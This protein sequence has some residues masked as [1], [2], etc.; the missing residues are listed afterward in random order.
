MTVRP[1]LHGLLFGMVSRTAPLLSV[2][3][4]A[5]P[6][7]A[8]AIPIESASTDATLDS[9]F[10][11]CLSLQGEGE[12]S[13]SVYAHLS[14]LLVARRASHTAGCSTVISP[15]CAGSGIAA[16]IATTL[17]AVGLVRPHI[18]ALG[19]SPSPATHPAMHPPTARTP[20]QQGSHSQMRPSFLSFMTWS[21]R[22]ITQPPG[23]RT[24]SARRRRLVI[25]LTGRQNGRHGDY[26]HHGSQ[27]PDR[28]TR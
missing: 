16:T 26:P 3:A 9:F 17:V 13:V 27:G 15:A 11:R 2:A 21:S 18:R 28:R 25:I 12:S 8:T 24:R 1:A 10:T 23:S 5:D 4:E 7:G 19:T 14:M 22:R 6:A 20:A